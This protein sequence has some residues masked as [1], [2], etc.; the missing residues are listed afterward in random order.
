MFRPLNEW[1]VVEKDAPVD[2]SKGGI[3]LPDNDPKK[4]S[5]TGRVVAVGPGRWFKD[6]NARVPLGVTVGD[7]VLFLQYGGT[8]VAEG[9]APVEYGGKSY[10]F[11]RDTDLLCVLEDS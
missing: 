3:M 6:T 7:R 5:Q 4:R 8:M 1:L 2:R 10:L 9:G 11:L